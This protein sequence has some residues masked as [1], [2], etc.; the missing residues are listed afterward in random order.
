MKVCLCVTA[1]T[2]M[3][4]F[5]LQIE[6]NY[7]SYYRLEIIVV[8]KLPKIYINKNNNKKDYKISGLAKLTAG[9]ICLLF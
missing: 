6:I 2:T 9:K 3:G 4:N 1:V 7:K 5:L 8:T